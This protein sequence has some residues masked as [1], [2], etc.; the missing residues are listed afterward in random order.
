MAAI[1]GNI[2]CVARPPAGASKCACM[3]ACVPACM[4]PSTMALHC[5][6][7]GACRA[8]TAVVATSWLPV[9]HHC[10]ASAVGRPRHCASSCINLHSLLR[11]P[12]Q[13]WRQAR[14]VAQPIAFPPH[15]G[16]RQSWLTQVTPSP[17]SNSFPSHSPQPGPEHNLGQPGPDRQPQLCCV[18]NTVGAGHFCKDY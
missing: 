7:N 18:P 8:A 15:T 2:A 5:H 13:A 9:G 6:P 17:P 10:G 1:N 3:Y 14:V 16:L 12:L 11:A 4:P